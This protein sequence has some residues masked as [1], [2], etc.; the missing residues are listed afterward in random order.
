MENKLPTISPQKL[1]QATSRLCE[2]LKNSISEVEI[3]RNFSLKSLGI[4][5]TVAPILVTHKNGKNIVI[6][7]T[8]PLTPK[9]ILDKKLTEIEKESVRLCEVDELLIK[10]NLPEAIK[11]I[12]ELLQ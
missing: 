11:K 3:K 5:N 1:E 12:E 8:H 6:V 4:E 10:N 9:Y 7:I 2:Y